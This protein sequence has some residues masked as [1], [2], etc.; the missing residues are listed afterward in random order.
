[1]FMCKGDLRTLPALAFKACALQTKRRG[2]C[3]NTAVDNDAK[4]LL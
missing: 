1:M 2:I 4:E 3:N